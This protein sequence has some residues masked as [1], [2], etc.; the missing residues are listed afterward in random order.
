M[1]KTAFIT[2][3]SRGIGAACVRKFTEEGY[4]T[5]FIYGKDDHGAERVAEE[6]GAIALKCDVADGEGISEAAGSARVFFG[7][8]AFDVLVCAAGVSSWGLITDFSGEEIRRTMEI[9]LGGVINAV[10]ALTPAMVTRGKG[11]IV[12][13]SSMWGETG[14]SCESVYSASKGAVDAFVKSLAKELGPSG[15][16]VNSVSPGVIDT[17]MNRSYSPQTM[18]ALKEE[19]PLARIG[20][21]SEVAEAV[22]FMASDRASFITGQVLG[23]NG[24]FY[25]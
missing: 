19:T 1:K 3:G 12:A 9:N 20:K 25:I 22:F 10:K 15:I 5:A 8:P 16:R 21:A 2:G 17:D 11:S 24:G 14:A 7:V 6:T 4:G 18:N 23:V 13:V